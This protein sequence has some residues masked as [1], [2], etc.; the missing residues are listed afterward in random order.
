MSGMTRIMSRLL[1]HHHFLSQHRISNTRNTIS[2]IST[3][4]NISINIIS[5][6]S[7]ILPMLRNNLNTPS[8]QLT[9]Y[10]NT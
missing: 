2:I 9:Q 10:R 7:S 4:I 1:S 6:T 5:T 8:K 3:H